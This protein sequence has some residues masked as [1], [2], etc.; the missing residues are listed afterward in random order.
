M[1]TI[2]AIIFFTL[3]FGCAAPE[4]EQA[5]EEKAVLTG[6]WYEHPLRIQQTVLRQTDAINYN[7]DSVMNYLKSIHANVLV[8][9]GG[10]GVDFF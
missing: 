6:Y 4:Q 10:G 7:V 5:F 2:Y 8:I 1:K 9:N 3:A